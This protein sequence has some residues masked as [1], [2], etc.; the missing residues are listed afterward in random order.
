MT[1]SATSSS[2]SGSRVSETKLR[3][4]PPQ[5]GPAIEQLGPGQGD[6]EQRHLAAWL[7]DELDE[8]EQAVARPVE[9]LDDEQQRPAEGGELD[10]RAPGR[11]ERRAIGELD[12]AGA[13]RRGQQVGRSFGGR[14]AGLLE[15]AS[16]CRA[17]AR[18][19]AGRPGSSRSSRSSVRIGQNVS[20]WPY[21]RHWAIATCT[22]GLAGAEAVDGL[23]EQPRLAHAGRRDHAD[24][25]RAALGERAARHEVELSEVRAAPDE[26]RPRD[27][28]PRR[29]SEQLARADRVG[30]ALRRRRRRGTGTRRPRGRRRPSAHRR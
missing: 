8:V 21:G 20:R 6:H 26:R 24:Q 25:E 29:A 27:V 1:S 4:P 12:L 9:V 30:L 3:R 16:G 18:R 14:V 2:P 10:R 13:D 11:E 23:L 22:S 17:G 28:G 5:C 19:V 15:P 7:E